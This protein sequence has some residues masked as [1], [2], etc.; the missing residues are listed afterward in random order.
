MEFDYFPYS[1]EGK[2]RFTEEILMENSPLMEEWELMRELS[3]LDVEADV[4]WCPF[5]T[6]SNGEQAKALL[7][8][9]FFTRDIFC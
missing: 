5:K 2:N 8:A 1:V 6:L 3:Y 7:A 4:L 9:L